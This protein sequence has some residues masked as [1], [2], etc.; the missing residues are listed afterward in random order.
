MR[1]QIQ[2]ENYPAELV[3]VLRLF[4]APTDQSETDWERSFLEDQIQNFQQE[5]AVY[6][7][8][9]ACCETH[10]EPFATTAEVLLLTS[11][12]LS[13]FAAGGSRSSGE[14]SRVQR[15]NG[16]R[17]AARREASGRRVSQDDG[18]HAERPREVE[19]ATRR[20]GFLWPANCSKTRCWTR[21]I[22]PNKEITNAANFAS[23]FMAQVLEISPPRHQFI[24]HASIMS[25]NAYGLKRGMS[26]IRPRDR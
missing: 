8:I 6:Q 21:P 22:Q 15:E 10:L 18:R 19:R 11:M 13:Q 2:A 7:S 12:S 25:F 16:D 14:R 24:L 5:I 4:H 3:Q 23:I 26:N 17:S 20:S 9:C 1:F